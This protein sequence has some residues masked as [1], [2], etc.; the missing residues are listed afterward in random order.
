MPRTVKIL[1][2]GLTGLFL[3]T[4]LLSAGDTQPT[5]AEV[6][7]LQAKY[8]AERDRLTTTG[9]AKMF[10][11]DLVK[12]AEVIARGGDDALKGGRLLQA[13]VAYRQAR[14]QL[15]CYPT[16]FPSHVSRVFGNLRLRHTQEVRCAAFSPDGSLLATGG[17]DRL[18]RVWDMANGYQ[19]RT[20][21]GHHETVRAVAFSPD[22]KYVAS[23]GGRDVRLWDPLTG[24]DVRLCPGQGR[25]VITLAFSPDGRYLAAGGDDNS[26]RVFEVATGKE[27]RAV[28]DFRQEVQSVAFS[29][30][31][32]LLLAGC[33]DG[34][35]RLYLF[36][37]LLKDE[38]QVV[39]WSAQDNVGASHFVAFA[40]DGRA[41]V[42]CGT[43]AI[44]LYNATVGG[45]A[46]GETVNV[47][48]HRLGT[49]THPEVPPRGGNKARTEWFTC[50]AFSRGG[51]TLFTGGTDGLV[52][53]WDL[54][55]GAAVGT[56]K[57][58]ND[59]V[60]ALAFTR[61]G[62]KL[63]SASSDFT[64]RLWSFEIVSQSREYAGHGDSVWTAAFSPEGQ[65][66]LTAS[67]DG[68]A[69]LWD[70]R[71]GK[72]LRTLQHKAGV[73]WAEFS[74]DGRQIATVGGEKLVKVWNADTGDLIRTLEGHTGT[75]TALAWDGK[76]TRL[77]TGSVDRTV[78]VWDAVT[79]KELRSFAPKTIVTA[80]A[81]SPDDKTIAAGGVDQQV[82]FWD[83]AGGKPEVRWIAHNGGVGGLA[84]SP[85][86]QTLATCGGDGLV[87]LWKTARPGS[88]PIELRGHT[89]PLSSVAFRHDGKFLVSAGSDQGIKLWKIEGNSVKEAQNFRGHKD[90]VSSVAFSRDG[91]YVVSAACDRTFRVWEITSREIP[92]LAEHTGSVD[93][94]AVSPDGKR[95]A[96]AGTDG[97]IKVWDPASGVEVASL[98]G[99][100]VPIVT[101]AFTPDGKTLLS[102]GG[103]R[104]VRR[105]DVLAG[106]ELPWQEGHNL[107]FKDLF[108]P[109][110]M[111]S[112]TPDGKRVLMWMPA[113]SDN[114][115]IV[116]V[117]DLKSGDQ[118]VRYD[119]TGRNVKAVAFTRDGKFAAL[120]AEDGTVRL[121]DLDRKQQ[122]ADA[123]GKKTDW[124]V[125][126]KAAVEALAFTPDGKTLIVGT[127]RGEVKVFDVAQRKQLHA[128]KGHA[129]QVQYAVVRGDGKVFATTGMDNVVKLWDTAT[130]KELR[131]WDMREPHDEHFSF[132]GQMAFTPDGRH[133]LTANS[134]TTVYMLELP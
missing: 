86:G 94:V 85:D 64:V 66:L 1:S 19:L 38:K 98:A 29:P 78:K 14:W 132:V 65:R 2:A 76:G 37:R 40:P 23:A 103:D 101:L 119:A 9:A 114:Y 60:Q 48:P 90:W 77:V 95:M 87:K 31:G 32:Q 99:P 113:K 62:D 134:N 93:A 44:K 42:R 91:N 107:N 70:V 75:V 116:G 133:L 84:F 15:P 127:A 67:G 33:G 34:Q 105:W 104:A 115:T 25:Y 63:A 111:L 126:D 110:P 28:T 124:H 10:L 47:V 57:G 36:P 130:G 97:T 7:Q 102:A 4:A 41:F 106:K 24:K 74:P 121:I 55:S 79:G 80:V 81:F 117:F 8:R 100:G 51:T 58:H 12:R 82:R 6:S 96:S 35:L 89:G 16:D 43:D 112:T 83:A 30:D 68:T 26:L 20:Y 5:P 17:N 73:T 52:R 13:A 18:I 59:K 125:A 45:P 46:G 72:V 49:L 122:V 123:Q 11:P 53:L 39:D 27:K 131:A 56:F 61:S 108:E 69:K 129:R 3:S 71:S 118:L 21:D 109:V 120:G 88:T 22:G 128:L 54:D 92:L 50:A